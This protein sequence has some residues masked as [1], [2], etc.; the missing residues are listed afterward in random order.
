MNHRAL[1]RTF[2][3]GVAAAALGLVERR[4]EWRRANAHELELEARRM[5]H[6]LETDPNRVPFRAWRVGHWRR[7]E[8]KH[9]ARAWAANEAK[10]LRFEQLATAKGCR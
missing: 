1:A 10:A 2:V 3:E 5:V 9:A 8:R 4:I 7:V 6:L